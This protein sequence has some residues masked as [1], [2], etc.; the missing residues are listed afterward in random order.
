MKKQKNIMMQMADFDFNAP[1]LVKVIFEDNDED[2]N[3]KQEACQVAD[4]NNGTDIKLDGAGPSEILKDN[5]IEEHNQNVKKSS[6][7]NENDI[8]VEKPVSD[9]PP[10]TVKSLEINVEELISQA[11]QRVMQNRSDDNK[12]LKRK[13]HFEEPCPKIRKETTLTDNI[14]SS[15][16]TNNNKTDS[17]IPQN[18]VSLEDTSVLNKQLPVTNQNTINI[19]N[20]NNTNKGNLSESFST[21]C[22]SNPGNLCIMK[23]LKSVANS[24]ILVIKAHSI[25]RHA[26]NKASQEE[27]NT[28]QNQFLRIRNHFFHIAYSAVEHIIIPQLENMAFVKKFMEEVVKL[29]NE[30]KQCVCLETQVKPIFYELVEWT[31]RKKMWYSSNTGLSLLLQSPHENSLNGS[32]DNNNIGSGNSVLLPTSE[33]QISIAVKQA[34]LHGNNN[35]STYQESYE[36]SIGRQYPPQ[37]N[38]IN[39]KNDP[40]FFEKPPPLYRHTTTGN[41]WQNESAVTSAWNCMEVQAN[42]NQQPHSVRNHQNVEVTRSRST[43]SGFA[44]PVHF[45]NTGLTNN[46]KGDNFSRSATPII[47]HITSLN[48]DAQYIKEGMC[49]V[50]GTITHAMCVGCYK[51]YYCSLECQRADW[52]FHS[53]ICR[54]R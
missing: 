25:W 16:I 2:S 4:D 32:A 20:S 19:P 34:Y 53:A 24:L 9:R 51:K 13:S 30:M 11:I 39:R 5:I 18:D 46:S 12:N 26:Q 7:I 41:S 47:T 1:V 50:C 28:T 27:I 43:D 8:Y 37:D 36:N 21:T 52:K 38:I 42:A 45:N 10:D 48:P 17:C 3:T 49:H 54:E 15:N 29:S 35:G 6:S 44:S 31:K 22:G 33:T 23:L 40:R 14:I